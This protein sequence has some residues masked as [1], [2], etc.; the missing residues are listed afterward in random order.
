MNMQNIVYD[1]LDRYM[2]AYHLSIEPFNGDTISKING[3]VYDYEIFQN[4]YIVLYYF[5]HM[6]RGSAFRSMPHFAVY[7]L[8]KDE[9]IYD[10]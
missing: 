8:R 4:G 1:L 3:I 2:L 10:E 6:T 9:F 7:D 5:T